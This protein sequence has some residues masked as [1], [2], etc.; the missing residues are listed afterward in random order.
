MLISKFTK[1]KPK[2]VPITTNGVK[3]NPAHGE[4]Y[5]IHY[6]IKSARDL[7][8]VGGFLLVL[9]F[10]PPINLPPRYN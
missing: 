9:Q 6:V 3:S 4:V 7:L 5:S 8:H 2:T 10:P 1:G